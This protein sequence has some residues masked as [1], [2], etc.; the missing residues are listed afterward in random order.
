M[1]QFDAV[2]AHHASL[3]DAVRDRLAGAGIPPGPV[4]RAA[5]AD[6]RAHWSDPALVLSQTCGLP[7]VRWLRDRV[8]P[9]AGVDHGLPDCAPGCYRSRIVVRADDPSD[10][11]SDLRGRIVAANAGHSQSGAGVWRALLAPLLPQGGRF[12]GGVAMTGAHVASVRAVA[13]GVADVAAI[14]AATWELALRHVPEAAALRVLTSTPQTPGLPLIT[15]RGRDAAAIGRAVAAALG[16][17][18]P[19]ARAALLMQGLVPREA[20]DFDGIAAADAE[21]RRRGHAEFDD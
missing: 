21:A 10:E 3:C 15:A 2:A 14:D 18:G 20:A 16:D 7:F 11:V 17:I 4:L 1:Y 12:F 9:V 19:A 6:L 13:S 8:T 5:P